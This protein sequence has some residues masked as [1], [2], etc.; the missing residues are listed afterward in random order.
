MSPEQVRGASS[1]DHRADLYSLGMCFFNMVTGRFTFNGESFGS[2]LV[3]ICTE[4]LTDIR[5]FTPWLSDAVALWFQRCCA[6]EPSAR[7][8]SADEHSSTRCRWRSAP[9]FRR[10]TGAPQQ[11][12][13]SV[14]RAL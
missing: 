7:Y 2:R 9:R 11:K 12:S 14:L 1:V 4:P 8:Q 5:T 6:R 3:A 10:S 13:S